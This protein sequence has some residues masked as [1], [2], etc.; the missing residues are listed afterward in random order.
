[1]P[2]IV[3][4]PFTGNFDYI[5]RP[6]DGQ[7]CNE[8]PSGV[9]DG[10]NTVFTT[11]SNFVDGSEKFYLNGNRLRSGVGCDYLTSESGGL[12]TGFDTLTLAFAP[13]GAPGNPDQLL[14]D[15]T[16]F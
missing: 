13:K 8:V 14:I 15:Y 1:M 2:R 3:F 6:G 7:V 5:L 9:I 12:G 11:A 10:A 16:E 4:N